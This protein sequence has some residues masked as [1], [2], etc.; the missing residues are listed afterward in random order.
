MPLTFLLKVPLERDERL[1]ENVKDGAEVG[2]KEGFEF[3]HI[4]VVWGEM[5]NT[6]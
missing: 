5:K 2:I 6:S 1:I 4:G 3:P